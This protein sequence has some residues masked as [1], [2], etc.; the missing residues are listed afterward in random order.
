V[1]HLRFIPGYHF[2]RI[3]V[4]GALALVGGCVHA[5]PLP[6]DLPARVS[7]RIGATLDV[8]AI[9]ARAAVLA[10]GT[11]RPIAGFDRLSV[12]A[13]ILSDDPRV[14]TA[15]ANVEAAR[16]DARLARKAAMP[17]LSLATDYTNDPSMPSPWLIG[18]T[19]DVPLDFGGRRL[20]RLRSADLS[21]IG[22]GYDL[23]D[24]VWTDRIAAM[25]GLIDVCAGERQVALG[26]DLVGLYDRQLAAMQRRVAGGEISSLTMAQVRAARAAAAR[27][28]DDARARILLGRAA[29]ATVLGVPVSALDGMVFVW[30]DFDSVPPAPAITPAVKAAALVHR[31]DVLHTI[32]SYDQAE[33]A[34]RIEVA[35]QVPSISLAPGYTWQGGLFHIPFGV[36][37][38]APSFDLNRT[39]IRAAEAHRAAAGVAIE[40]AIADAQGAIDTA[41][42]E[43]TAAAAALARLTQE[44]LPQAWLAANRADAQLR[45]GA[46]DRADWA[47]AKAANAA[48]RLAAV[49]TLARLHLAQIALEAALR[50]PLDGPETQISVRTDAALT[51]GNQP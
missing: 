39:A 23:I 29:I 17:T 21:V 6:V 4:L 30:P 40:V 43:R 13:A 10:P 5:P 32:V 9:T 25:R 16:R 15:R 2:G 47:V 38:Q 45:L 35:K 26:D 48:A 27:T 42:S 19:A 31:A 44:E 36:N 41:A 37:L 14:A 24:V 49:D 12:F 22:A 3:A 28:R 51:E 34:L 50:R 46:I 7:A 11:L 8:P 18:V 20:G 1:R 33:A